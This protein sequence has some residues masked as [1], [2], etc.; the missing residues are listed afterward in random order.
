MRAAHRGVNARAQIHPAVPALIV[1]D[2][3][4]EQVKVRKARVTDVEVLLLEWI[5]EHSVVRPKVLARRRR[6]V[7]AARA[8]FPY[9]SIAQRC[10]DAR[11]NVDAR[12]IGASLAL[13]RATTKKIPPQ[14]KHPKNQKTP[15]P[16]RE[17]CHD[18][19]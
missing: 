13:A 6:G 9:N 1:G 18:V 15:R 17:N 19:K 10:V 12:C 5:L 16:R 7:A 4:L 14:L 2:L 8:R 11:H 3:P